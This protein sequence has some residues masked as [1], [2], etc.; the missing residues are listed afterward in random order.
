MCVADRP[1]LG[2]RQQLSDYLLSKVN[3]TQIYCCGEPITVSVTIGIRKSRKKKRCKSVIV[4][5][6]FIYSSIH[7]CHQSKQIPTTTNS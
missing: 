5:T 7:N 6:K 1:L 2:C 4:V 3:E